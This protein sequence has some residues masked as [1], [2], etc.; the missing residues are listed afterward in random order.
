MHVSVGRANPSSGQSASPFHHSSGEESDSENSGVA[1]PSR[2]EI[3]GS[4]LSGAETVA[5][6]C[7][8]DA[9]EPKVVANV[10]AGFDFEMFWSCETSFFACLAASPMFASDGVDFLLEPLF[11]GVRLPESYVHDLLVW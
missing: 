1:L 4:G 11:P 9:A 10:D 2:A 7:G 5:K 6:P 3:P 8:L